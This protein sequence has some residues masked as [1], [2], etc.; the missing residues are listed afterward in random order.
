MKDIKIFH[1]L[2][3]MWTWDLTVRRDTGYTRDF[4]NLQ[5][6]PN[7]HCL[8]SSCLI[9]TF[10]HL[11]PEDVDMRSHCKEG[12]RIYSR[13][14]QPTKASK[15]TL[16]KKFLLNLHFHSSV[17]WSRAAASCP[18]SPWGLHPQPQHQLPSR[19]NQIPHPSD[20]GWL[21]PSQY[22]RNGVIGVP[23][24]CHQFRRLPPPG[25]RPG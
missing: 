21:W 4:S 24:L 15:F 3:K 25:R 1:G 20:L 14:F 9:Y 7:L 17:A 23:R 18:L 12:Y 5:R 2:R 11:L 6:F 8:K 10:I 19:E 22:G 13:F 16:F